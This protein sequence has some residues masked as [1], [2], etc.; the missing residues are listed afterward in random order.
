MDHE[1][2]NPVWNALISG[3]QSLAL[4]T[5]TVKFFADDVAP[6]VG[7]KEYTFE[8]FDILYNHIK[9]GRRCVVVSTNEI[10]FPGS[11]EIIESLHVLQMVYANTFIKSLGNKNIIS[12]G[13]QNTEEMIQL[14][15][16]THPGPFKNG[17]IRFGHYEGIFDNGKLVA[18]AGQRLHPCPYAEISAVC[19]HPDFMKKG[20]ATQLILSQIFRI[21]SSSEIPFLHVV[22][23]NMK[24]IKLYNDLGFTKRSDIHIYVIKKILRR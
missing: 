13:E 4:G 24:A 5:E 11:W 8:N 17:T 18:M 9:D 2:D 19:T 20:L 22:D 21:R 16:L 14:T 10:L 15:E 6:F 3:N 7:L 12:L 1:L 23:H